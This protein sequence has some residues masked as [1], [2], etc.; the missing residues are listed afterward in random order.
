MSTP[1]LYNDAFCTVTSENLI[2]KTFYFPT[3][4]AKTIPITRISGISTETKPFYKIKGW[5]MGLSKCWYACDLKR[6]MICVDDGSASSNSS[7]CRTVEVTTSSD[8]NRSGFS[9]SNKALFET[10]MN[11]VRH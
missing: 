1:P 2:I 4:Q 9:V 7:F 8:W 10:A 3:G 5:G 6:G 11:N